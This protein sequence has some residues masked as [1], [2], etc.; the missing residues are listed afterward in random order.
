MLVSRKI[1]LA[2]MT[3]RRKKRSGVRGSLNTP[4][5]TELLRL[6][7]HKRTSLLATKRSRRH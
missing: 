7:P 4:V 3:E 1:V 5:P 2:R 6:P